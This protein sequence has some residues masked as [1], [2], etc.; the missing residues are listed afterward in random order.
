MLPEMLVKSRETA[1]FMGVNNV[2]LREGLLEEIPVEDGWADA[3]TALPV[4]IG[5]KLRF[6]DENS[7]TDRCSRA[8][9]IAFGCSFPYLHPYCVFF[10]I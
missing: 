4:V 8:E 2:E 6:N 7:L 9:V 10:G 5:S 1:E 3:D